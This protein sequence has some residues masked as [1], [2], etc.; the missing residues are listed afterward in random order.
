MTIF[1]VL[2]C[3]LCFGQN[4]G[5]DTLKAKIKL[6]TNFGYETSEK[7]G[8][9]PNDKLITKATFQY[10][11]KGN[12][13]QSNFYDIKTDLVF[14][15]DKRTYDTKGNMI[16]IT[17]YDRAGKVLGTDIYKYDDKNHE[18]EKD[19][20]WNGK[21]NGKRIT[22]YDY[23]KMIVKVN[24]FEADGT[25]EE[26]SDLYKIDDRENRLEDYD[27]GGKLF[28]KATY[29]YDDKGNTIKKHSEAWEPE[30]YNAIVIYQYDEY[31]NEILRTITDLN[32]NIV[33]SVKT[34]YV[35]DKFGNWIEQITTWSWSATRKTNKRKIE[36]Y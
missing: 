2:T 20:Y 8:E 1:L 13:I 33:S 22:T 36:Y 14:S 4:F 6:T 30:P 25:I 24:Y 21:L 23:K 35:Y 18:I 26:H 29:V 32:E 9:A 5:I 27:S 15:V 34:E 31:N 10:N 17:F 7:H 19:N 11:Q 16:E 12:L 3:K 28:S